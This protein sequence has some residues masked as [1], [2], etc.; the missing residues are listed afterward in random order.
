M[1]MN[2]VFIVCAGNN[3]KILIFYIKYG[4]KINPAAFLIQQDLLLN[5][6][7]SPNFKFGFAFRS[8]PALLPF[9]Y[10]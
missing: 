10:S 6:Y 7:R 4:K 2:T 9:I 5:Y 8:R 1:F 3:F